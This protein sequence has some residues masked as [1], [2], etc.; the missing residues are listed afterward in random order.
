MATLMLQYEDRIVKAYPV[1]PM[2]TIGRLSDNAVVV[3]NPAVS[4]HHACVFREGN[5][6]IIED[7]QS[8][9]GTFVNGTRVIRQP[10]QH[11]DVVLVGK[12]KLVFDQQSMEDS[13]T[14]A[15]ASSTS[16]VGETVF[17]DLKQHQ[18]LH[19]IVMNAEAR[20]KEAATMASRVGMLR[21]IEGSADR[22]E[23]LLEGH[24]SLIGRAS[25]TLV[26]LKGWFKPGV[27][28][29]ITRNH[30]GYVATRLRGRL[31]VN[32]NPMNGRHDL[33]EGDV[34]QVGGLTLAF[35]FA[36]SRQ[37]ADADATSAVDPAAIE[38]SDPAKNAPQGAVM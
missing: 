13:T 30:H 25:W 3:D 31:L 27:A 11:G 21:V 14:A 10:L 6:F 36:D 7:L 19:G 34:L 16:N 32:D 24:T 1:A 9:N 33:K 37:P 15:S 18:R 12:H 28:V 4:S 5:D 20:A 2:M 8:T 17:L 38:H 26:R 22:E 23:Y 29:A 35:R